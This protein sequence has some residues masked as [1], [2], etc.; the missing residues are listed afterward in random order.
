MYS[1]LIAVGWYLKFLQLYSGFTSLVYT[2]VNIIVSI[3]TQPTDATASTLSMKKSESL[4]RRQ[5]TIDDDSWMYNQVHTTSMMGAFDQSFGP[6]FL[7]V[8]MYVQ[9]PIASTPAGSSHSPSTSEKETTPREGEGGGSGGVIIGGDSGGEGV[10]R[11]DG[12][13]MVELE[14]P[15]D[16]RE[17]P[18]DTEHEGEE[19]D[20][21]IKPIIK[22]DKFPPDLS[23]D[24]I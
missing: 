16:D 1:S 23:W 18:S 22:F 14:W 20:G 17:E 12:T 24:Q 6:S 10:G 8:F 3:Y 11:E 21:M 9:D 13:E 15:N 2:V 5:S 4:I 7:C 19:V